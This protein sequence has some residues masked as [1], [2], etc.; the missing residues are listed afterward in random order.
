MW[1]AYKI[2]GLFMLDSVRMEFQLPSNTGCFRVSRAAEDHSRRF[3]GSWPSGVARYLA[4]AY[5]CA[6]VHTGAIFGIP[7]PTKPNKSIH[8]APRTMSVYFETVGSA[9]S[10]T[11]LWRA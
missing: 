4:A 10:S 6:S 7:H 1:L 2:W 3:S 8:N 9:R 5:V 11:Y